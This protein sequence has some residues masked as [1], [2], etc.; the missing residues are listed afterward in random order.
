ML[1]VKVLFRS[2]LQI[3]LQNFLYLTM[4]FGMIIFG[5]TADNLLEISVIKKY[6]ILLIGM[7]F[8]SLFTTM[9]LYYNDSRQNK[10]L[11]QKVD[12]SWLDSVSQFLIA[13]VLN[14]F[15]G[16]LIFV[17]SLIFNDNVWQ[18]VVG[19][20]ALISVG[21]L[22]S[23]IATICKTQWY[24]HPNLGQVGVLVFTYLALSGSVITVLSYAELLFPPVSKMVV[25]LQTKPSI[26]N[27]FPVTG[28]AF[29]YSIILFI[30]SSFIYKSKK[31]N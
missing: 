22:G 8:L 23:S 2:Y 15:S 25:L 19:I 14:I 9:N 13:L 24:K 12:N 3:L 6:S 21:M 29:L 7:F 27:L 10:Y 4:L 17:F 30:I 20:V 1:K 26:T 31:K 16:I 18:D 28:Q 5:L 11:K